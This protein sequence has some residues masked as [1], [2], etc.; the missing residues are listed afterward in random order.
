MSS[1]IVFS[2][3]NAVSSS[4]PYYQFSYQFPSN[5]SFENKQIAVQAII[6]PYS[7]PN[8]SGAPFIPNYNNNQFTY[9]WSDGSTG[10]VNLGQSGYY[11]VNTLNLALDYQM[12]QNN[13]YTI[14][15]SNGT[16]NYYLSFEANPVDYAVQINAIPVPTSTGAAALGIV[17]PTGASWS[18]PSQPT[19]PQIVIPATGPAN[20]SNTSFST[21]VGFNPGTYPP[22]A[23]GIGYSV[24]SQ[25]TPDFNPVS[26][27]IMLCSA[28]NNEF[29]FQNTVMYAINAQGVSY[30]DYITLYPPQL[31][32]LKCTRGQAS[33]MTITFIDQN[34]KNYVPLLDPT[35]TVILTL[36]DIPKNER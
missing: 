14:N 33:S 19:T 10:T 12:I 9:V 25:F 11:D 29:A 32:W 1:A 2:S 22:S 6:I 30:G 4:P 16:F 5:V 28:V 34:L 18:W 15:S 24:L 17:Q 23:T 7:W 8:I 20:A 13:Q 26:S 3:D 21:L 35:I 27:V 31:N 36:R